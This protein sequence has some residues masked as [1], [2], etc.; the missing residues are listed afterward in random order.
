MPEL[1]HG[2]HA[3]R[4]RI[5]ELVRD[6]SADDL[7]RPVP[8]CPEWVASD[9]LAH[10]VGIPEALST[11]DHPTGEMQAWLDRLVAERREVPVNDLLERWEACA[12]ATSAVIDGAGSLLFVDVVS[13]EHDLRGAV[14]RA[15]ARGVPE[16]RATVQLLLDLLA[17]EIAAAGLGALVV[18]SGEVTWASQFTRPGCTIKTDPWEAIRALQSRRSADELRALPHTGDIEPYLAVL[19]AHSPLPPTS[20]GEA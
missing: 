9:L 17:P 18:D 16:V 8:A 7:A 20:L 11:G 1:S 14:G 2:Y 4:Q 10:V 19:H 12:A 13:H 3:S 6:L 5:T 15:G